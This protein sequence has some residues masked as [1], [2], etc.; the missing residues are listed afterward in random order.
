MNLTET[1]INYLQS[2]RDKST[3]PALTDALNKNGLILEA[4]LLNLYYNNSCKPTEITGK[5]GV[6][7][8]HQIIISETAPQ[9]SPRGIVWFDPAE[10]TPYYYFKNVVGACAT[11]PVY[12]W[13][14]AG[15][16][17]V[18]QCELPKYDN[19]YF[20][21][22]M[23]KDDKTRFGNLKETDF[24]TNIYCDESFTYSFWFGKA[25]MPERFQQFKN[26]IALDLFNKMFP[27]DLRFWIGY[28]TND[29]SYRRFSNL[30]IE[31]ER[32]NSSESDPK[33]FIG[34]HYEKF[35]LPEN[36]SN[37]L[38]AISNFLYGSG[39]VNHA[40]YY[41]QDLRAKILNQAPR[42]I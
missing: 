8:D 42:F 15:F 13:Q 37:S 2:N 28:M 11:H 27:S 30:E 24:V 7:A 41:N 29:E 25:F 14:Y 10:L 33:S 38:M 6:F 23:L 35:T 17:N 18:M 3:V 32:E 5:S 9:N 31:F 16:L 19:S 40:P 20:S 36:E 1:Y 4:K 12:Y 34:D 39:L 26:E 22:G 21:S